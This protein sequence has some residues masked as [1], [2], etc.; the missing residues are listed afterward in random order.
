MRGGCLSLLS[1]IIGGL[2]T[3]FVALALMLASWTDESGDC[4]GCE[5]AGTFAVISSLG[6]F[7]LGVGAAI[8]A[9]P[10]GNLWR[11][12]Q[13][14]ILNGWIFLAAFLIPALVAGDAAVLIAI[15]ALAMTL[16]IVALVMAWRAWSDDKWPRSRST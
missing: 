12:R 10:E 11:V 14:A 13:L 3:L 5:G 2:V 1:G 4:G 8:T 15:T 6:I 9:G 7:I 16:P